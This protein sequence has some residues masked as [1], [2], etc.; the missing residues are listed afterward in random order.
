MNYERVRI[1]NNRGK[2]ISGR[3]YMSGSSDKRTIIY[4]HGLLSTQDGYKISRMRDDL[5]DWGFDLFTFDF[6]FSGE[7][8]DVLYNLSLEQEVLDLKCVFDYLASGGVNDIHIIG[9]S[10]GGTVSLMAASGD[11]LFQ[12]KSLLTSLVTIASPVDLCGLMRK[13]TATEN[14]EALDRNGATEIEGIAVNNGFFREL[15]DTDILRSIA[16]LEVP[17]LSI[18]GDAD[19]TVAVMNLDLIRKHLKSAGRQEIITGGDHSLNATDHINRLKEY[20]KEWLAEWY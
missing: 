2:T 20:V 4:C 15:C 7:S 3:L 19:E 16:N 17:L 8:E 1:K 13:L 14:P 5:L 9:S 10:M 11:T 6:S 12:N 18:H